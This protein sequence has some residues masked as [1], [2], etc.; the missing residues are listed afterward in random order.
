[1]GARTVVWPESGAPAE[2]PSC[3]LGALGGN[4]CW[5]NPGRSDSCQ[6]SGDVGGTWF[7]FAISARCSQDLKPE[8]IDME[9]VEQGHLHAN[10]SPPIV[11]RS[12]APLGHQKAPP[13]L[14]SAIWRQTYFQGFHCV[15]S[16]RGFERFAPLIDASPQERNAHLPRLKRSPLE[17]KRSP[18][19]GVPHSNKE[20]YP[21]T[22]EQRHT[23]APVPFAS[24]ARCFT[25]NLRLSPE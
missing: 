23:H 14:G 3:F 13:Q 9:R 11:P 25:P 21:V 22:L 20:G 16:L 15:D 1:M 5:K 19:A 18:K 8:R 7:L 2:Y 12:S 6:M 17:S 4:A 24:C 10:L